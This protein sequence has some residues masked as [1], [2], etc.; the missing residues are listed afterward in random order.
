MTIR[1]IR[2]REDIPEDKLGF[3]ELPYVLIKHKKGRRGGHT[4]IHWKSC[5]ESCLIHD[6][7]HFHKV[8]FL[9]RIIPRVYVLFQSQLDPS[10]ARLLWTLD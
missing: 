10:P 8:I 1:R 7:I 5:H 9:L 3:Q 2:L 4:R 6:P